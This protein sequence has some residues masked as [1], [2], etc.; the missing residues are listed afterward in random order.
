MSEGRE[1]VSAVQ[2]EPID[3]EA[4]EVD[5]VED[6]ELEDDDTSNETARET[7]ERVLKDLQEEDNGE[8]SPENEEVENKVQDKE[9][10][11]PEP[12][13][14][15]DAPSRFTPT[16]KA[17][18]K[19]ASPQMKRALAD[20]VSNTE[21]AFTKG[22]TKVAA[23]EKEA[24]HVVE[25][26]RPYYTQHPELAENGYSESSFISGLV[27]VHQK[28]SNPQTAR[29]EIIR[30][31]RDNGMGD[32]IN[33]ET[34]IESGAMLTPEMQ[35]LQN[36]N[37]ELS[38]KV[39]SLTTA[40][41]QRELA[42]VVNQ[43][44]QVRQ[45]KDASGQLMYPELYDDAFLDQAKPLVEAFVKTV[46]GITA[47]EALLRAHARLT[48]RNGDFGNNQPTRLPT[49]DNKTLQ[50]A[51]SAN[52]SVRGKTSAPAA[53]VIPNEFPKEALS[54]NPRDTAAWVLKNMRGN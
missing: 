21:S 10:L 38:S 50:R 53:P 39:D 52:V 43:Y 12:E 31:A 17:V 13:V 3:D 19:R 47:G 35:A 11:E 15:Y 18:F 16:Q 46:P 5:D 30:I 7:A 6:E 37:N 36:Q 9:V 32:L 25:A 14:D 4:L 40:E 51:T 29:A 27:A 49:T 22:M 8:S 23:R 28:L 44:E 1:D 2:E 33:E 20:L 34:A 24:S 42:P 26:V 41:R 45:L 54:S 48:G